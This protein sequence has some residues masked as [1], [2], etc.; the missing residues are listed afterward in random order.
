MSHAQQQDINLSP[1]PTDAADP[2]RWRILF[3]L[4]TAIF[5]TL[6]S[7]SVVNVA[8]ASIQKGL[9][10][11][12]ADIQWV[13]SGYALTFGVVLVS[14]GRAG[15]LMGRGGFFILGAALFTLA[16]IA[17]GL[18]PDANWLN[19]ARF[20][21]GVGSGFLNPQ[22]IGMIQQYFSGA[23]RG[24]AFGI[25]GISVALSVSILPI[26]GGFLIGLGGPDIGWRLTFLINV[27]VGLLT[28]YL[29]FKWFPRPLI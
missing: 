15:D 1:P 8:L 4:L 3:V 6:M 21:Q 7:V 9:N 13:L 2:R 16:S 28:I 29:A 17:A 23:D 26:M 19:A 5:L 11:S 27:P 18:A 25:F 12:H 10:A 20:V 24:S 14:A 22:G